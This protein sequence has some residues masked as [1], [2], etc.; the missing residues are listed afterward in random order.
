MR[1]GA[2]KSPLM[3][4]QVVRRRNSNKNGA[5]KDNNPS[6]GLLERDCGWLV[7]KALRQ[8]HYYIPNQLSFQYPAVWSQ[9]PIT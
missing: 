6:K 5:T 2:S 1:R 9:F 3:L 7:G 8:T 4:P